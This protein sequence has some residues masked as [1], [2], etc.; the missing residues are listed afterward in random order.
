MKKAPADMR[1]GPFLCQHDSRSP[2]ARGKSGIALDQKP[3]L[4]VA[5]RVRGGLSCA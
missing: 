2:P 1:Q 5:I 4:T 3:K